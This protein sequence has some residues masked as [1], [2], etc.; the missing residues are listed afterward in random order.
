MGRSKRQRLEFRF[1]EIPQ[2]EHVLA[3]LG[4]SWRRVYGHDVQYMHFHN[5]MEIGVCHEGKGVLTLDNR[6]CPY[7]GGMISVIP[8][9][10]PHHTRSEGEDF[11][12]Y[13]YLD[14][15]QILR[16]LYPNNQKLQEEKLTL[17]NRRAVLLGE[18]E[19]AALTGAAREIIREM[20]R[21]D[22]YYRDVVRDLVK[23]FLLRLLRMNEEPGT[24]PQ[25]ER[26][27]RPQIQP[28]LVYIQEQFRQDIRAEDLARQCGLSEPHFRRVFREYV[29]MS[30]ID[31]LNAVRIREACR[32]MDRRDCP[33]DLVAAE[34]GFASVSSFTRNFKKH[35]G[36]TPY[37]WKLM[38]EK[39][40]SRLRDY[41]I[42]LL[43]GWEET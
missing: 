42:T 3:L 1:Y 10:C 26:A 41:S 9:N 13:L 12:E 28:A 34:C 27:A 21:R 17:F 31:Y 19:G 8:A 37:Q 36:T 11:W 18:E 2:N 29:D 15:A 22:A 30:P 32:M 23:I 25:T 5:L 38:R 14:P 24:E 20:R 33:M 40:G 6:D 16:E 4:D 39:H 35:M 7:T 43:R